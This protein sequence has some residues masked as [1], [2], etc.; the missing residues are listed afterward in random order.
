M[1]FFKEKGKQCLDCKGDLILTHN[2]QLISARAKSAAPGQTQNLKYILV[3][4]LNFFQKVSAMFTAFGF[5]WGRS[6]QLKKEDTAYNEPVRNP[7]QATTSKRD[8]QEDFKHE[9]GNYQNQCCQCKKWFMG[10]KRRVVCK[11]CTNE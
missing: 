9:N 3:K 1:Y 8:W 11:V 5:I 2:K 6:Q 7:I 4:K 10:H